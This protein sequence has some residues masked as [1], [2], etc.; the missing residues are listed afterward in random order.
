MDARTEHL[1]GWKKEIVDLLYAWEFVNKKGAWINGSDEFIEMLNEE[2]FGEDT[3]K[4]PIQGDARLFSTIEENK[5][6]SK[7]LIKFFKKA[8]NEFS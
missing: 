1:F 2:G 8:I 5:E 6:L 7:F 4:F 3:L